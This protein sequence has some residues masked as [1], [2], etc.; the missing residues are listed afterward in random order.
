MPKEESRRSSRGE[1][2]AARRMLAPRT[3]CVGARVPQV[4][5]RGTSGAEKSDSPVAQTIRSAIAVLA[6]SVLVMGVVGGLA[7]AGWPI[8]IP[9]GAIG[10]HGPA[11][12]AFFATVIGLERAIADRRTPALV[13]PVASAVAGGMALSGLGPLAAWPLLVAAS[14]LVGLLIAGRKGASLGAFALSAAGAAVLSAGA[15]RWAR[16]APMFDI[17]PAF[18]AFLVLTILGERAQL[19]EAIPRTSAAASAALAAGAVLL[20]APALAP[21]FAL[22]APPAVFAAGLSIAGLATAALDPLRGD[23]RRS[24]LARYTA[25]GVLAGGAWL[26]AAGVAWARGP[27]V[28]GFVYDAGVHAA[29]LGFVMSMAFAHAPVVL[30]ELS[31]RSVRFVPAFYAP[32]ALLQLSL[33]VRVVGDALSSVELR[34]AGALGNGLSMALFGATL[35]L[36]T[37]GPN[38]TSTALPNH[39]PSPPT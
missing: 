35:L 24:G 31:G 4:A 30:P 12:I 22:S 32:V 34:R 6:A 1:T 3:S 9:G 20:V 18:V 28:A 2:D 21:F 38:A 16:G 36:A 26:V 19:A 29:L 5:E 27:M 23:L 7:R 8:S 11:L 14:G 25:V 15:L 39:R 17:V 13:V 10:G 33:G 37:R